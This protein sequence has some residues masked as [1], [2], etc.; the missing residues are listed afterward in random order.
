M[1]PL[2][3]AVQYACFSASVRANG[4]SARSACLHA[5][6]AERQISILQASPT[7]E[8]TAKVAKKYGTE[9]RTLQAP[10][11]CIMTPT[12]SGCLPRSSLFRGTRRGNE[13]R[14]MTPR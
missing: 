5:D 7:G 6:T 9:V 8:A 13:K 4:F 12:L 14:R 3:N 11:L 2:K 10:A 1:Q